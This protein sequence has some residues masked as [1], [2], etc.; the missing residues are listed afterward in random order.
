MA[1][2]NA[3]K[4]RQSRQSHNDH[5]DDIANEIGMVKLLKKKYKITTYPWSHFFPKSDKKE[6]IQ[7]DIKNGFV[8]K[9][10]EK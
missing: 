3:R 8:K 2:F 10:Y 1:L 5:A 4:R 7:E 6:A 9:Y